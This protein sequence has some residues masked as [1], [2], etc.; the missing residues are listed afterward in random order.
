MYN[1]DYKK[2]K[3]P[4]NLYSQL[5][6]NHVASTLSWGGRKLSGLY[7]V[8]HLCILC[9]GFGQ[10]TW[11]TTSKNWM[12]IF[13]FL[14]V[15]IVLFNVLSCLVSLW[16]LSSI[17]GWSLALASSYWLI[18]YNFISIIYYWLLILIFGALCT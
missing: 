6:V 18:V 2:I 8:V 9:F 11:T 17:E 7:C 15:V 14:M 12:R 16:V 13:F 5:L 4:S 1:Y 3:L 10:W